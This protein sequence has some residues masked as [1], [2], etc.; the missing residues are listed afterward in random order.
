MH[1]NKSK[2]SNYDEEPFL[3]IE[4]NKSKVEEIKFMSDLKAS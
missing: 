1:A 4:K 2:K 3:F